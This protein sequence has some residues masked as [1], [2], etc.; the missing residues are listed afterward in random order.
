MMEDASEMRAAAPANVD[1]SASVDALLND[2]DFENSPGK[3][4]GELPQKAESTGLLG[5]LGA[6]DDGNRV[7]EDAKPFEAA[8]KVAEEPPVVDRV[9]EGSKV[10]FFDETATPAKTS[11]AGAKVDGIDDYYSNPSQSQDA[12]E[13]VDSDDESA[14]KD[15][16]N[17]AIPVD[18]IKSGADQALKFWQWGVSSLKER[19]REV[20]AKLQEN[21]KVRAA[22]EQ[23]GDM[24][25]TQ[26]KPGFEKVVSTARPLVGSVKE[27]AINAYDKSK[28]MM[29]ELREKSRPAVGELATKAEQTWTLTKEKVS[30]LTEACQPGIHRATEKLNSVVDGLPSTSSSYSAPSSKDQDGNPKGVAPA[31]SPFPDI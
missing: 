18:K 29:E 5:S 21:E 4:D 15:L 19:S 1:I 3:E 31:V 17:G 7:S 12:Q 26:V 9:E 11:M 24:Y 14:Q 30:E 27:G 22:T 28:P 16:L 2:L 8:T 25:D 20:T 6:Q 23:L 10:V 13:L